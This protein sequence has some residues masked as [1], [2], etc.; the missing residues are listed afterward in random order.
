MFGYSL[1]YIPN[2]NQPFAKYLYWIYGS[3]FF[4]S[5]L[6]ILC[7]FSRVRAFHYRKMFH[8]MIYLY[9]ARAKLL[10]ADLINLSIRSLTPVWKG[11]NIHPIDVSIDTRYVSHMKVWYIFKHLDSQWKLQ[12]FYLHL[13][14]R[15]LSHV[16][17][18]HIIIWIT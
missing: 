17:S 7:K 15:I 11:I 8:Q 3:R 9:T 1:M 5:T 13:S 14:S 18:I 16:L 6:K 2:K 12:I 4:L 10:G